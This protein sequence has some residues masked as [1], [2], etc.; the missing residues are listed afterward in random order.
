MKYVTGFKVRGNVTCN[1]SANECKADTTNLMHLR[2]H[3]FYQYDPILLPGRK[4]QHEKQSDH[5]DKVCRSSGGLFRKRDITL[6]KK[7]RSNTFRVGGK[8]LT[9]NYP[10]MF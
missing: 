1:I 2:S 8:K 5:V 7:P 9:C 10:H 4:N 3:Q 6:M